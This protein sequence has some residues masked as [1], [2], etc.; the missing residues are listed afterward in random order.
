[1]ILKFDSGWLRVR[2]Y[3]FIWQIISQSSIIINKTFFIDLF[4][5]QFVST[6]IVDSLI[7]RRGVWKLVEENTCQHCFISASCWFFPSIILISP[8]G[9]MFC[10]GARQDIHGDFTYNICAE[11][12]ENLQ[13]LMLIFT[14]KII[15]SLM[16]KKIHLEC[17]HIHLIINLPFQVNHVKMLLLLQLKRHV[18]NDDVWVAECFCQVD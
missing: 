2:F 12:E 9:K 17:A 7:L 11:T 1:M 6:F 4:P 15:S 10:N 16:K 5:C 14:W 18:R 13:R 8:S 3:R